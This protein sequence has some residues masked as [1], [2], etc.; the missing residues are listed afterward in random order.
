MPII[1]IE[2][3]KIEEDILIA[4]AHFIRDTLFSGSYFQLWFLQALVVSVILVTMLLYLKISV[5]KIFII[6]GLMYCISLLGQAYYGIFDYFFPE[7]S[8]MYDV[9]KFMKIIFVTPRDGFCFGFIFFFIGA[10]ISFSNIT[11]SS[12]RL[13]VYLMLSLLL[14]ILEVMLGSFYGFNRE[15]DVYISLLAVAF[16]LFLYAKE[17]KLSN[18]NLWIYLRKQSMYIYY[19]HPWFLFIIRFFFGTGKHSIVYIG[20]LGIFLFVF[21]L[22]MIFGHIVIEF[23]K[24][25]KYKI[26][27]YLS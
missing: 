17:L 7:G 8:T 12:T 21:V 18:S 20:H 15:S 16:F 25:P 10:Y 1:I 4:S 22:S 26:L 3:F 23:S 13:R 6:A 2:R 9:W 11:I 14:L 19:I 27:K 5:K 24:N